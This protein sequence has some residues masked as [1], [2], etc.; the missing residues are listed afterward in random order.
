MGVSDSLADHSFF[1]DSVDSD[2]ATGLG[3]I[4]S[5]D[6]RYVADMFGD[7]CGVCAIYADR[8][9]AQWKADVSVNGDHEQVVDTN[10][11]WL[12]MTYWHRRTGSCV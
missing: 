7:L 8:L 11:D 10:L 2:R 9:D 4:G 6:P 3:K 5:R 1:A 12:V